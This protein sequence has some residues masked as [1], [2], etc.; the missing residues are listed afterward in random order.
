MVPVAQLTQALVVA[1]L[2]YPEAQ[3]VPVIALVLE[4]VHEEKAALLPVYP[5]APAEHE[6]QTLF[7]ES[8]PYPVLHAEQTVAVVAHEAQFGIPVEHP[9]PVQLIVAGK[10]NPALQ[11]AQ[12]SVAPAEVGAALE[13]QLEH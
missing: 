5:V 7:V 10:L 13:R 3:A 4:I 2:T 1:S 11:V 8:R 9:V 12:T 6:T